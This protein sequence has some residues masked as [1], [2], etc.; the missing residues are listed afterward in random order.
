M[1]L[2]V[3][4][5]TSANC[6]NCYKCVRE[7]PVKA[8]KFKNEKAT[9]V[10]SMCIGCGRCLA[11]CPK[12]TK[13]IKTEV[14]VIKNYINSGIKVAVSLAPSFMGSF[15]VDDY[16]KIVGALKKL[17]F[18]YVEETSEAA[19][20]ISQYYKEFYGKEDTENYITTCCPSVNSL[21][22][23]YYPSLI[24]N[25]IPAISPMSCHSRLLKEKYGPDVKIVFIGPCLSKKYEALNEPSID[26]V[27][28]FDELHKWL[29]EENIDLTNVEPYDFDSQENAARLYPTN[30]G[31]FSTVKKIKSSKD[32][33][34][35]DGIE[36]CISLL[37]ELKKGTIK[38]TFIEMSLCKNSC[39]NGPAIGIEIPNVYERINKIK[40][41]AKSKNNEDMTKDTSSKISFYNLDLKTKFSAETP[42][43]VIPNDIEIKKILASIGK[44]SPSDELNCSSCGY[45]TC[46]EKAIAVY[47]GMAE[48]Y[49]CLPYMKMRA[50]N[51][52][53]VIFY[54]TPNAILIVNDDLKI[55]EFNPSA[56]RL[57]N[58]NKRFIIGKPFSLLTND[59]DVLFVK[60]GEC[61]IPLKKV[62]LPQYNAVVLQT[63]L[64]LKDQRLTL[65]IFNDVTSEELKDEKFQKVKRNTLVMAQEVIDNQM[66]V[67]QEIASLLGE[68]TA[69]TKVILTQLKKLVEGEDGEKK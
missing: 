1:A 48:K 55:V 64:Y 2:N 3:F 43:I 63:I 44:V 52:S 29:D 11:V 50:E 14:E 7:C 45:N 6:Q 54:S 69:E 30:G 33:F 65:V 53:N 41:Y 49:M 12:N 56:E 40:R 9:I 36:D 42:N 58:V 61:S 47:N 17:N 4:K 22:E 34:Q 60:N 24:K 21:I 32:G 68:T 8:I 16:K 10:D 39:A 57:F 23:K 13:E 62:E 35:V 25:M 15:K 19:Y 38:N 20:I 28:T 31:I 66:R 26:A 67:A 46:K 5:I 51:L 18:S 27:L 59:E 37:D